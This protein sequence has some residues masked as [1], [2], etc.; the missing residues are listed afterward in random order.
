[1]TQC[2]LLKV[3][4]SHNLVNFSNSPKGSS[5]ERK[6]ERGSSQSLKTLCSFV[7]VWKAPILLLIRYWRKRNRGK[8][9]L[10]VQR[11]WGTGLI[12]SPWSLLT[13][14]L[15]SNI[16]SS[17]PSKNAPRE[18]LIALIQLLQSWRLWNLRFWDLEVA[19][20]LLRGGSR[21]EVSFLLLL[22]YR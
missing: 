7:C 6:E 13:F 12:T 18:N 8:D 11:R 16:W 21:S 3:R 20:L 5:A 10:S 2:K 9:K 14:L 17:F 15:I 4:R 1:M 19:S 22:K